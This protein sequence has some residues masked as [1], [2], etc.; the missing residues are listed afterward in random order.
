MLLLESEFVLLLSIHVDG[1]RAPPDV[2]DYG[3][4]SGRS[5]TND[6]EIAHD[7][8]LSILI[9]CLLSTQ[10]GDMH[11]FPDILMKDGVLRHNNLKLQWP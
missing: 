8:L 6:D 3:C 10:G 2:A 9:L 4:D 1:T 11:R 5:G 7:V